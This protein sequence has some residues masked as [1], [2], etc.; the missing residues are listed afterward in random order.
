MPAPLPPA[1]EAKIVAAVASGLTYRQTASALGVSK[2]SIERVM[3][4]QHNRELLLSIRADIRAITIEHIE[5]IQPK[6]LDRLEQEVETG[7]PR[8]IDAV[9]RAVLNMEKI[10]ASASG[11]QRRQEPGKTEVVVRFADWSPVQLGQVNVV[12]AIR[13][14]PRAL[15]EATPDPP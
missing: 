4:K 13:E 14:E 6:L 2:S 11:E 3:K 15:P 5:H 12:D 8:D 1:V 7:N 10:A 9:S